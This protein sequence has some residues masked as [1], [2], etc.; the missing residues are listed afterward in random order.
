MH[1]DSHS[2]PTPDAPATT[3]ALTPGPL[4]APAPPPVIPGPWT[5]S[6]APSGQDLHHGA[7]HEKLEGARRL[8]RFRPERLDTGELAVRPCCRF[9]AGSNWVGP[10]P[11]LDLSSTG[12]AAEAGDLRLAPGT[13]IQAL[14]VLHRDTVIW[15]G[16]GEVV[17]R[18]EAGD[19]L[20][21]ALRGAP[22]DLEELRFLDLDLVQG[23][24]DG[25]AQIR[26]W[27]AELPVEWR[28][29]VAE[30]RQMLEQARE[31]LDDL[32]RRRSP[33]GWWRGEAGQAVCERMFRRWYP[34][35]SRLCA[36]L[37]ELSADFAGERKRAA[38]A[39]VQREL[40]P[41]YR[42]C[43]MHGR[44]WEKPLGYAG[45]YRLMELGQ[46]AGLEGESLY[47][48]FLHHVGKFCTF[49]QTVTERGL[50][51]RR[52]ARELIESA[53]RPVRIVSLACGPAV[54]MRR[55]VEEID[56][57]ENRVELILI[58]QDLNALRDCH[59][60]MQEVL[61]RRFPGDCP[62]ELKMIHFSIRQIVAPKRGPEQELVDGLLRGVD[63]IY[64]M[65][66][67]DYIQQPLARRIVSRLFELLNPGGRVFIGNLERV[68]DCSWVMDYALAWSLVYRDE[69]TMRDLAAEIEP[70]AARVAVK[71]DA[72]GHCLFLDVVKG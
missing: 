36:E 44:A 16:E 57:L 60:A 49:G 17:H 54:E 46:M 69:E 63:L 7:D 55:L 1:A 32:Q 24:E 59:D 68:P 6:P 5:G 66:L 20:G 37:D 27:A 33:A 52:V 15:R 29:R 47:A 31:V 41:L 18:G 40:V 26:A 23:L 14:E 19:R 22:F 4:P 48:R 61:R 62:V 13:R 8:F 2:S 30:V 67:Y 58:D 72:T 11:I 35:Y 56:H 34:P 39:Y 70:G 53:G 38:E 65:G 21:V 43:P 10:L 42:P 12:L 9:L 45:D 71:R 50:T 64:S 25:M 51:A 3:W 28:A